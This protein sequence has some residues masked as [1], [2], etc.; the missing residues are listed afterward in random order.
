MFKQNNGRR[1]FRIGSLILD[2]H[3][4]WDALGITE[5]YA[6]NVYHTEMIRRGDTVLDLGAGIGDFSIRASKIVGEEGNVIAVEPNPLDFELLSI[7]IERNVCENI[8]PL[9][10]GIADKSG[11]LKGEF[12]GQEFEFQ[13]RTMREILFESK[14][15]FVN[16]VKMD[17]EGA[18]MTVIPSSLTEFAK[19][20]VIAIELHNNEKEL[21]ALLHKHGFKSEP[22]VKNHLT[23]SLIKF[24]FEHPVASGIDGSYIFSARPGNQTFNIIYLRNLIYGLDIFYALTVIYIFIILSY[25]LSLTRKSREKL[26]SSKTALSRDRRKI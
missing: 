4:D 26:N 23:R 11:S 3:D 12:K 22:T 24:V 8:I 2:Y 1:T 14:V 15:D 7:N 10:C 9:N 18:E 21:D 5:V 13:A 17:I 20:R 16:F 19:T 25:S 6:L